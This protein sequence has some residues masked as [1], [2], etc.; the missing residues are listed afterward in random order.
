MEI[1][2]S[3]R[4]AGK[5]TRLI[6][7][8]SEDNRRILLTF[9][10]S[11]A[12]RLQATYDKEDRLG[13]SQRICTFSDYIERRGIAWRSGQNNEVGIDNADIILQTMIQDNLSLISVTKDE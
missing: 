10:R 3:P 13:F 2:Y 11:E 12:E 7:W 1:D 5:T 6:Q 8:L 4:G 9:S